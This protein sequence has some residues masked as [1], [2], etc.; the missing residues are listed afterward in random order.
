M[1][2]HE[3]VISHGWYQLA[4]FHYDDQTR[5]LQR[6]HRLTD[7]TVCRL[8]LREEHHTLHWHTDIPLTDAQAQTV[9]TDVDRMMCLGWALEDFYAALADTPRYAWVINGGLGRLLTCPTVWEDLAKTLLTTNTTWGQTR[10][11][12]AALCRLG[13]PY[14]DGYA[15]PTPQQVAAYSHADL[16]QATRA[17]Y[18]TGSLLVLAQRIR[19][20]LDVEAWRSL[21]TS[22]LYA[23]VRGLR[24]Y[25][26][27]AAGTM[28]RLLGHFD[29]VAIDTE[30]RGGYKR[31]SG[32][33]T[34]T[35][36]EIRAFYAPFGR[37]QG[38]AS[39]MDIIA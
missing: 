23:A 29:R 4:P 36:R 16:Q 2:F 1:P 30:C 24:G 13:T 12:T 35:D 26:D 33:L 28:L 6:I 39:W 15:F 27:Y 14:D 20:G 18:R 8:T 34:A 9:Q 10:T 5:R 11:M 21:S 17:G 37:W 25:G 19:D 22:D 32:S 3:T 31:A 38:L 7:G